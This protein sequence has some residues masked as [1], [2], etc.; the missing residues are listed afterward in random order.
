M[1]KIKNSLMLMIILSSIA[2]IG[3]VN[4]QASP[5]LWTGCINTGIGILYNFQQGNNPLNPC[6]PGDYNVSFYDKTFVDNLSSRIDKLEGLL[7]NVTRTGDELYFDKM[8]VHVRSGTNSTTNINGFGNLI[9]GYNE[10]RNDGTDNRTG[11]NNLILGSNNNYKRYG[12]F[13]AGIFNDISGDYSSVFGGSLNKAI[14]YR[15]IITGGYGNNASGT[16][17]YISSGQSNAASG[18]AASVTGGISNAALGDFSTVSGGS[19]RNAPNS[20]NWV[21]GG[22]F[23]NN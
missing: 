6:A 9:I 18:N 16:Y 2:M 17:S 19:N 14:G 1:N 10:L 4:A 12:G 15:S 3:V 21:A 22:L 7:T 11:S 23:Q 8:N 13:V 5:G 20:S